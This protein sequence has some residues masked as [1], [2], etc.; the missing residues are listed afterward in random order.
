MSGALL[1]AVADDKV[2]PGVLGFLVVAGLGVA[3]WLLVRSM[4]RQM[5]KIDFTEDDGPGAGRASAPVGEAPTDPAPIA[6]VSGE[7]SES[8]DAEPGPDAR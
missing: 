4:G 3:T 6:P 1:L 8:G 2:T 5:R 7:P